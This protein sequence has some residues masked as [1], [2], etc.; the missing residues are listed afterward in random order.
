MEAGEVSTC[1][2]RVDG[3]VWCWGLNNL[4]QL[5]DGLTHQPSSS[6]D[7]SPNPVNVL[8]VIDAHLLASGLGSN[9]AMAGVG[10]IYC[11]G[12]N[13]AGQLGDGTTIDR[14]TPVQNTLLTNVV[15]MALGNVHACALLSD[16]SVFC[17]G[18]NYCGIL[19]DGVDTHGQCTTADA[20]CSLIPVQVQG[21]TDV[22]Q[23]KIGNDNS[24][25]LRSD[26]TV[27]CWGCNFFGHFAVD[28]IDGP[29]D[30]VG[31]P[32]SRV[33]YQISGIADAAEISIG[34]SHGCAIL[35]NGTA[36]CWGEGGSGQ[37]GDGFDHWTFGATQVIDVG[38]IIALAAGD[39]HTCALRSDGQVFCW[40]NGNY[41]RLGSGDGYSSN[42]PLQVDGLQDVTA[43]SAGFGHTCALTADDEIWC[44]G[45]NAYGQVGD[46]TLVDRYEPVPVGAPF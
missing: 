30:C 7:C 34:G 10:D 15:S 25:A 38:Y 24:C 11:W 35:Q 9:C 21:L 31:D 20:D 32:C 37:H 16:G 46:G 33:P 8:G 45:Y 23:I 43:I 39:D 5:G 28:P 17:W 14:S 12:K 22:V 2:V 4:G 6:G 41:G 36:K 27:H 19:G 44:W 3:S 13:Y 42:I 1:A 29:E 26:G 40:G 18:L